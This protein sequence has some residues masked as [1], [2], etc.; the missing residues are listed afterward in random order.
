MEF[1]SGLITSRNRE[2]SFIKCTIAEPH[3]ASVIAS[4]VRPSHVICLYIQ[5]ICKNRFSQRASCCVSSLW[6]GC[7]VTT[8][9]RSLTT[10]EKHPFSLFAHGDKLC[11]K[12]PM[13]EQITPPP[14][15]GRPGTSLRGEK[16][17]TLLGFHF[18]R[19]VQTPFVTLLTHLCIQL[20]NVIQPDKPVPL[21]FFCLSVTV[22][23]TACSFDTHTATHTHTQRS[24]V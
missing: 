10:E 15:T 3:V 11:T 4:L 9:R 20:L 24:Q 18:H 12:R 8:C 19:V 1:D 16:K 2:G 14:D 21:W 7:G 23:C 13:S 22:S 17:P 6:K 5:S